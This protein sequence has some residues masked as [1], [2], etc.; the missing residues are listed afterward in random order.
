VRQ[1]FAQLYAQDPPET[2]EPPPATPTALPDAGLS[3][4]GQTLSGVADIVRGVGKEALRRVTNL[5]TLARTHVPG[6]AALDEIVPPLELAPSAVTPANRGE[7]VGA[8]LEQLGEFTIPGPGGL[9]GQAAKAGVTGALQAA[10]PE[11]SGRDVAATGLVSA[12]MPA[13]ARGVTS[14]IRAGARGLVRGF[15]KPSLASKNIREARTIVDTV[16]R[17]GLP[18]S[19]TGAAYNETGQLTGKAGRLITA[20]KAEATR[21][22]AQHPAGRVDLKAVADGLRAWGRKTYY[23]PG[24]DLSD[25][26]AV[27]RV[28]DRIDAHPSLGIPPGIRPTAVRVPLPAAEDVKRGLQASARASYGAPNAA[29]TEAAEKQGAFLARTAIEGQAGGATA[30]YALVNARE[31]KLIPAAKAVVQAV[32]REANQYKFHGWKNVTSG[33]LLGGGIAAGQNP[34]DSALMALAFRA[35]LSPALMSRVAIYA[36]RIAKALGVSAG[37]AGRLAVHLLSTAPPD[38]PEP[39]APAPPT[40]TLGPRPPGVR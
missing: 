23:K 6:V 39:E 15:L 40:V 11:A 25:Y 17:E 1:L 10:T 18:V 24:V 22:L 34:E 36:D 2:R 7:R 26:E 38:L 9:L 19:P 32:E 4:F 28:A 14:G 29:A 30:P 21:L 12:A 33:M 13:V 8:F 27:L 16:I 20:L 5:G 3:P 31:A 35:G 37:V